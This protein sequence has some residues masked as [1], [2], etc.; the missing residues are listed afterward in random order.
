MSDTSEQITQVRAR[1]GIL[2]LRLDEGAVTHRQE[3]DRLMLRLVAHANDVLH[4]H[5]RGGMTDD[6]C[7]VCRDVW[8]CYEVR[9]LVNAWLP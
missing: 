6:W 8:P 7:E 1:L 5:G 3:D 2:E 9:S 4:L